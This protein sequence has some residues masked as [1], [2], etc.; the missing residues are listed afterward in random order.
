MGVVTT[1]NLTPFRQSGIPNDPSVSVKHSGMCS[2]SK[3]LEPRFASIAL[4]RS[5]PSTAAPFLSR[6]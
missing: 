2:G 1:C 6:R 5:A 3:V 4:I